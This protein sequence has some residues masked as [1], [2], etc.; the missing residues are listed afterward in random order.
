M[1]M[2][3]SMFDNVAVD[4]QYIFTRSQKFRRIFTSTLRIL[5]VLNNY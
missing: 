3:F 1:D 5:V 2:D 4:W